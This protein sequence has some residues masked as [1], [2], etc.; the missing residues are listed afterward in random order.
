MNKLRSQIH[1]KLETLG[2]RI[3]VLSAQQTALTNALH[4]HPH[5]LHKSIQ[6]QVA[7]MCVSKDYLTPLLNTHQGFGIEGEKKHLI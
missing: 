4:G 7:F 6:A 5:Q 1:Y 3:A 2:C